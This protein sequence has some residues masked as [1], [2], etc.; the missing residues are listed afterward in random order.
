MRRSLLSYTILPPAPK[1]IPERRH[2][3][4]HA[5]LGRAVPRWLSPQYR[6]FGNSLLI[7]RRHKLSGFEMEFGLQQVG[8]VQRGIEA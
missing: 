3:V 2:K 6:K 4:S 7:L 8:V 1:M 5:F